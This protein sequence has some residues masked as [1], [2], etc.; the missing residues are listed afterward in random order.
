MTTNIL[1]V[2]LMVLAIIGLIQ[3]IDI[4]RI[5]LFKRD[6]DKSSKW[7]R[8]KISEGGGKDVQQADETT[9]SF[10][11]EDVRYHLD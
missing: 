2:I 10:T 3:S 9:I 8:K 4:E 11:I 6:N 1:L 5:P 7:L